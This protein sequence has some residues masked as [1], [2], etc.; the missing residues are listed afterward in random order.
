MPNTSPATIDK[1]ELEKKLNIAKKSSW[2]NYAFL[3]ALAKKTLT[4]YQS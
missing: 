3:L 4:N 1:K 2:V